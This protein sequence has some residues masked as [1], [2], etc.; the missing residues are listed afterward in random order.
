MVPYCAEMVPYCWLCWYGPLLCW[1]GPLDCIDNGPLLHVLIDMVLLCWCG[2][3]LLCWYGPRV[4]IWSTIVLIRY[5]IA[6]KWSHIVLIWSPIVMIWSTIVLMWSTIVQII[7]NY[8][9]DYGFFRNCVLRSVLPPTIFSWATPRILNEQYIQDQI[10][11][12][13]TENQPSKL[14]G[15][16]MLSGKCTFEGAPKTWQF[17]RASRRFN[18][19]CFKCSLQNGKM[20]NSPSKSRPRLVFL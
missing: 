5:T 14:I 20:A 7:V 3:M 17:A 15:G 6:D 11:N 4:L 1:Y 9:A 19:D 10:K 8:C 18:C 16:H 12:D 13:L 2:P